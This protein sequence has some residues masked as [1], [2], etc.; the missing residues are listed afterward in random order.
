MSF[1]AQQIEPPDQGNL[2]ARTYVSLRNALVAGRFRPGERLVMRDLAEK[3][4]ASVTPVREACLRLVSEQALEL[5][6]GRFVTVP[7]LTLSR[8][9]EIRTIRLALEGLAADMAASRMTPAMIDKLE[10]LHAEF[11]KAEKAGQADLAMTRNREFHFLLYGAAGMAMLLGQIES[12]WISMGPILNVFYTD[13]HPTYVGGEEHL[14]LMKALRRR[15]GRAA[16][17]AIEQDILRGGESI[18]AYL[19]AQEATK[20]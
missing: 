12:L 8:Y 11:V 9:L 7:D 14:S 5:R 10:H 1:E 17:T 2:S 15:D 13:M 20:P 6:S 16:R 3:I 19:E 4:G 18:I